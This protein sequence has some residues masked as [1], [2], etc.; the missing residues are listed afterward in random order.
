MRLDDKVSKN[1]K[2]PGDITKVG[3][4]GQSYKYKNLITTR[5]HWRIAIKQ[6]VSMFCLSNSGFIFSGQ[7]WRK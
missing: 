2:K 3:T 5:D 4:G 7:P 1:A 6:N